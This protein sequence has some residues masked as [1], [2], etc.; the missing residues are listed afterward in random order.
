MEMLNNEI[1]NQ[2]NVQ[3]TFFGPSF[4]DQSLVFIFPARRID[5][6]PATVNP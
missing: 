3:D 2:P 1:G 5:K 6:S 4:W